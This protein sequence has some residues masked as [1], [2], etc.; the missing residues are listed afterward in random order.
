MPPPSRDRSQQD[1]LASAL[2]R[3][4]LR[5][6]DG[7]SPAD[8]RSGAGVHRVGLTGGGRAYLKVTAADVGRSR[9]EAERELRFYRGV[10]P[11]APVSTPALLDVLIL[12]EGVALL[13]EDAGEQL[14]VTA[15]SRDRWR[16]LGRELARL[17]GMPLPAGDWGRA[18]DLLSALAVSDLGPVVEFWSG[19]LP[20]LDDLLEGRTAVVDRLRTVPSVFVHGDCHTGNVVHE[21]AGG[22]DTPV[23]CDW[24]AAGIGRATS[25]LAL[26]S[27]RATPS[28]ARVPAALVEEYLARTARRGGAQDVDEFRRCLALEELAILVFQWP[29]YAAYNGPAGTARIRRRARE[30]AERL[31]G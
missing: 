27:V 12:D 3:F 23:F 8:A 31:S 30:L 29:S 18:D 2:E 6:S 10:A 5:L 13:L 4:G 24:Q 28:G 21:Q 11:A 15:W 16:L 19:H 14:A 7:A 22:H 1:V 17:H 20:Q 26:L 9:A 25:D